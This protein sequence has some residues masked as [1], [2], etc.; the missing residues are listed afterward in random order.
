MLQSIESA[1]DIFRSTILTKNYDKISNN[2]ISWKNYNPGIYK[3]LYA[4]EYQQL[5]RNKQYSLLLKD[6]K[7]LIQY[8]YE[9]ENKCLI[10]AKLA[11]YPYPIELNTTPADLEILFDDVDDQQLEM[12]YYDLWNILSYKF[13]FNFD[14]SELLK[15]LT[16]KA[17]EAGNT[18]TPLAMI[19]GIFNEKYKF[20][21]SSH[22]RI[23]YDSKV[24]SHHKCEIQIGAV[25]NIR[26]PMKHLI[27]PFIF[28][29]F[30]I[31]N[32]FKKEYSEIIKKASFKAGFTHSKKSS[33]TINPFIEDNIF[34]SHT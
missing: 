17:L 34:G 6:D 3:S 1:T 27:S 24:K 15:E 13:Q 22:L 4:K 2:T 9:F 7:G 30:L 20:T 25:N 21:N 26:L 28:T 23:D 10:K 33:L 18:E 16:K 31:K 14:D 29:D 32:L 12:Y 11:Y 5:I 19:L 8:Y